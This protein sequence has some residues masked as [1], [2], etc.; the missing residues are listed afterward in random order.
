VLGEL[1]EQDHLDRLLREIGHIGRVYRRTAV[2]EAAR[3]TERARFG[4]P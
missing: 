3:T 2:G 1:A 4:M